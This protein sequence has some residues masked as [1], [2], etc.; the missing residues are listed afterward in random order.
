MKRVKSFTHY[1]DR[2][3]KPITPSRYNWEDVK[4]QK[5]AHIYLVRKTP[6]K[7]LGIIEKWKDEMPDSP[8]PFL[9]EAMA[10]FEMNKLN[11]AIEKLW[12]QSS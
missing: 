3:R 8:E 12:K 6:Q 2:E 1:D 4:W 11:L 5:I 10:L 7:A 9:Y